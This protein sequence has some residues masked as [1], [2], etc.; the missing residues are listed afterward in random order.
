MKKKVYISPNL[1]VVE[2]N[3]RHTIMQ[4]SAYD[5]LDMNYEGDTS[6]G[7]VIEA[8]SRVISDKNLWDEEW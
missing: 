6:T 5:S 4:M 3:T 7:N 2:L 8:D 1:V